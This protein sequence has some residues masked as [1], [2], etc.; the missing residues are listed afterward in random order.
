MLL[1]Y[2]YIKL[3]I[4][5]YEEINYLI[6]K[7]G[8]RNYVN[9]YGKEEKDKKVNVFEIMEYYGIREIMW[10]FWKLSEWVSLL[11]FKSSNYD[12]AG[13]TDLYGGRQIDVNTSIILV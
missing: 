10:R 2:D 12:Y 6:W 4:K 3:D 7:N 1:N 13:N 11:Y 9:C 5:K 8:K